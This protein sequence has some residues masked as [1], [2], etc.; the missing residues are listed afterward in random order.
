MCST[1]FTGATPAPRVETAI[2]SRAHR[3]WRVSPRAIHSD[4]LDRTRRRADQRLGSLADC[5]T[6][7]VVLAGRTAVGADL[8]LDLRGCEAVFR[9][10]AA[11]G[12]RRADRLW[13]ATL[14]AE[15]RRRRPRL[16]RSAAPR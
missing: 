5:Q 9:R 7:V 2:F 4:G 8:Q 11:T 3:D 12:V 14:A 6:T 16:E 1:T 10:I 13:L 15:P